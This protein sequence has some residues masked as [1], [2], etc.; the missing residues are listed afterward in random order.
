[1]DQG[2]KGVEE[3]ILDLQQLAQEISVMHDELDQIQDRLHISVPRCPEILPVTCANEQWVQ[4]YGSKQPDI[5]KLQLQTKHLEYQLNELRKCSQIS[6]FRIERLENRH[7]GQKKSLFD[8]Q[9]TYN[10]IRSKYLQME[11][12][13]GKCLQRYR[14]N[15]TIFATWTEVHQAADELKSIYKKFLDQMYD[16]PTYCIQKKFILREI[17]LLNSRCV[18]AIQV[19]LMNGK[20]L[21]QR[22]RIPRDR[23][24]QAHKQILKD[25]D[26]KS[27]KQPAK[28]DFS[29]NSRDVRINLI[30]EVPF[31]WDRENRIEKLKHGSVAEMEVVKP[32]APSSYEPLLFATNLEPSPLFLERNK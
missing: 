4:L 22:W 10:W 3:K 16:K 19:T 20:E 8:L 27:C 11:Q 29:K 26:T 14:H 13:H 23:C 7:Y 15:R 21:E 12:N 1:D 17:N 28:R 18:G 2:E 9:N 30:S 24:H 31:D 5:K 25:N 32:L 6:R